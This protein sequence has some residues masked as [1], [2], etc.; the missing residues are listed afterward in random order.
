M[1]VLISFITVVASLAA[2]PGTASATPAPDYGASVLCRYV[3][4]EPSDIL[5]WTAARLDRL[6]V[7]PPTVYAQHGTQQV[8]WRYVVKRSLNWDQGPWKV[9]YRSSI[10][11][12]SATASSPADFSKMRVD[13][14]VPN[15]E[16]QG[17]VYY[18]L[19]L[20]IFWYDSNGSSIQSK[21]SHEFEWYSYRVTKHSWDQGTQHEPCRGLVTQAT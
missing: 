12:A 20:K 6:V 14:N 16:N 13:V 21:L 5:G 11:Q 4:T 8:G 7:S 17:H 2:V 3:I 15:V 1:R 18:V 19:T 10:Q 9:T